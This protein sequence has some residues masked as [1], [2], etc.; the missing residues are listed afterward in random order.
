VSQIGLGTKQVAAQAW[1]A[2]WLDILLFI[3]IGGWL[4]WRKTLVAAGLMLA[5][6][7]FEYWWLAVR[8]GRSNTWLATYLCLFLMAVSVHIREPKDDR[9]KTSAAA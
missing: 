5:L 3:S 7:V 8:F 9:A 1:S 4:W 6:V 2:A